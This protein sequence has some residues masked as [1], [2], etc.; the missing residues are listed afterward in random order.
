MNSKVQY[1]YLYCLNLNKI[2]KRYLSKLF[3]IMQLAIILTV[4]FTMSVY[5]N[6]NSQQITLNLKNVS[7]E[8]ALTEIKRQSGYQVLYNLKSIEKANQV[9]LSVNQATLKESLQK[10]FKDQ[11][12]SFEM[13]DNMILVVT[14]PNEYKSHDQ[15]QKFVIKGV[16]INDQGQPMAGVSVIEKQTNNATRTNGNG[17]FSL[18]VSSKSA[19][20]EFRYLGYTTKELVASSINEKVVMNEDIN[21]MDEV[22][23]VGYGK[24]KKSEV[25]ASMSTVDR[26]AIQQTPGASLQ[27]LLTGK[28]TG[29]FTQQRSGRPGG[30]GADMSI[31]GVATFNGGTSPLILVDDIEYNQ[32][33]FSM[34]DVNEIES[35]S[36][37]KDAEATAI[38]GVKGANGV[39]LVTTRRGSQGKPSINL[40]TQ[41]GVQI[42]IKTMQ[43]LGSFDAATLYNEALANDG[44]KA[45]FTNEEL[46]K[47]KTGADPYN[48]PDVDWYNTVYRKY[49]TNNET[50][51]DIS[52]GGE[53]IKYFVSLGYLNQDGLLKDI[54]YKGEEPEPNTSKVNNNYYFNRYK[55]RS[56]LDFQANDNLSMKLDL[57]GT[58]AET[59]QPFHNV[60]G[61]LFQYDYVRPFGYPVYNP[62]GSFGY[63]DPSKF[64]P[65]YKTNNVAALLALGGYTRD[66]NN[67]MNAGLTVNHKLDMLIPGLS[68]KAMATYSFANTANRSLSRSG[69]P[70]YY[71]N[72]VNDTYIPR[73]INLYRVAPYS[74]GY[75]GGT[76]NN[77]LNVQA[78]INYQHSFAEKHNV[79]GLILYNQTSYIDGPAVPVNFRGYTYRFGYNFKE[80]YVFSASGA[81]N[82]SSRFV[83]QKRYNFFPAFALAW[84]I[85]KEE[86]FELPSFVSNLKIRGSYGKVG[87][88]NIG[89]NEYL[90]EETYTRGGSYAFGE[91]PTPIT[92]IFEGK[93][94]NNNI[95][96]ETERKTNIGL[97]AKFFNSKLSVI[98]DYFYNYRHDIIMKRETI[99]LAFGVQPANLPFVNLGRVSNRGVEVELA[100][101]DKIGEVSYN[102]RG[103]YSYAK[104]KLI[105]RDDVPAAYPWQDRTGMSLGVSKQYIWEGGFYSEEEINNPDVPKPAGTV[106]P[107][108]LKYK[109]LNGDGTINFYDM[110]YVGR[111]NL[112]H[113]TASVNIGFGYKGFGISAL[114]QG[115]FGANAHLGFDMAVPFKAALQPLHLGR[116]TPE[117][118]NEATFPALTT[119]FAGTYMNPNQNLSTFWSTSADYIRLRSMELG[120]TL[121]Q[122]AVSKLK[123]RGIRVFANAYNL[124]TWSAFYKRYQYDPE[125]AANQNLYPYPVTR[126]VN[127]GV[128]INL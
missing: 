80:R 81:Y 69:I 92:T 19:L 30:D 55:F 126:I 24:Q 49:A 128:N 82:G 125:V 38:Y 47:F 71:Y 17:Q 75:G 22:V 98:V 77:R 99:P 60:S 65:S 97:D 102:I 90:F 20:I 15:Q 88:D 86:F 103:Q 115:S 62:N 41:L 113:T 79:S 89:I 122:E 29:L 11:P 91:N 127:L 39:I 54:E 118:A 50:N 87:N 117:T 21:D 45:M 27:N 23:V 51:L 34:I 116:W 74:L 9:T 44:L 107:G 1:S 7:L 120:Y 13:E 112:P 40:R 61:Q 42:P 5:G 59:N 104:N 85:D 16:V 66:Y 36:I 48:Y 123:L 73:D 35:V 2:K 109:D 4:V 18:E 32:G 108:F 110:A 124:V 68:A 46:E 78:H 76:P 63:A 43:T 101:N 121:P 6:A 84:N 83:S 25:T 57:T 105:Y 3:K 119:N 106:K 26:K 37:L 33:Q 58:Y 96:W 94:G 111:P 100:Y 52:G 64:E 56:N 12:L 14:K 67:F 31:R 72:G 8:K 95:T 10:V 114:F 28:V 93:Q 53:R 70:A